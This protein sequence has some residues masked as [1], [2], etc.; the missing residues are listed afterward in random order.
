MDSAKKYM[1]LLSGSSVFTSILIVSVL[2]KC[3]L[4]KKQIEHPDKDIYNKLRDSR[5]ALDKA[6][7]AIQLALAAM[8]NM[9]FHK[10]EI[11]A[12]NS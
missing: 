5:I 11:D 9:T 3:R 2:K 6:A 7:S 12:T 8:E 1:I 4:Q 10:R